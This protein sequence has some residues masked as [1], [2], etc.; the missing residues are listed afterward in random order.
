[1]STV[2]N[3]LVTNPPKGWEANAISTHSNG[4][5]RKITRWLQSR[6]LLQLE[7]DSSGIDLVHVHVTHS[8]S[9]W[10]KLDLLRV[11]EINGI[12]SIVHIHSGKFDDFCNGIMGPSVKMTLNKEKRGVIVLEERWKN[13]LTKWL[14]PKTRVI[15]NFPRKKVD[16]SHHI[17]NSKIKMLILSRKSKV[18][19]LDFAIEV[20]RNLKQMGADAELT[21]TGGGYMPKNVIG[22]EENLNITGWVSDD[23]KDQL[24]R[25]SD[26]LLSPSEF[27]GASMSVIESIVSGLPCIVSPASSETV[28]NEGQVVSELSPELWGNKILELHQELPY[29]DLVAKTLAKASIYRKEE[30]LRMLGEFYNEIT[31]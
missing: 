8:L 15:R 1:M 26:F 18:K 21:I 4:F 3:N 29:R 14:P 31:F 20:L 28:M 2:I 17:L 22:L 23:Q 12:P 9:W 11:C 19:G 7:F 16:R 5:Y 27:E 10:R 24:I 6:R 25:T 30:N 13:K